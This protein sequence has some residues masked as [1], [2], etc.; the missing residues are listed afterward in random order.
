MKKQGGGIEEKGA[1]LNSDI[2]EG[3]LAEHNKGNPNGHKYTMKCM[4]LCAATN[5]VPK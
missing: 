5:S 4:S 3:W 2:S 1:A